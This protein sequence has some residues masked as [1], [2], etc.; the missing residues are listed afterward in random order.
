MLASRVRAGILGAS[1]S[2]A[3]APPLMTARTALEIATR[4]SAAV[5]GRSDIGSLEPG[6]CADFFA[7]NLNKIDYAGALHDPVSAVVFCAPVKADYTVV[8]G[9]IIVKDG[10]MVKVDVPSLILHHNRLA[11]QLFD[12]DL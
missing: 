10:Q 1:L 6:K 4:G 7:V 2:D 12:N 8:G 11:A 9:N 5:L 3:S